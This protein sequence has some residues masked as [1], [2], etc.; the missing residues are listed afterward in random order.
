M[1]SRDHRGA[2]R[3][4]V[5]WRLQLRAQVWL[6]A[7]LC[8]FACGLR[9]WA[10]PVLPTLISDHM[11]LQ[12]G[13]EIHLWGRADSGEPISVNLAGHSAT[14]IADAGHRW[15]V[16][17]PALSAGGPF[18]LT[19]SGNKKIEVKDVMIGEV[20][21]ASGQSNMTFPLDSAEGAATEVPKANYPQIRLFTVP[22]RIALSPQENTRPT[23]WKVCTP[24]NA[25]SFSAVGYFFAREIHR[26]LNVPVG[27]VE[28]AW[29]G[30]AIED[31][32]SPHALQADAELKPLEG[33]SHAT[34]DEKTFAE[35]SLP[36]ELEFDDFELIPAVAGAP[37]KMLANFDDG[38]ARVSTSG[39]FS[40][41][42]E[43]AP[44]APFE[45]ASP[46]HS[47]GG[48]AARIVGRLDGTQDAI[49]SATYKL[50]G[51]A[52]D[53]T[54]YEGIRFWVRGNGSFRFRSKQPTVTDWDDYAAPVMKAS[55]DWKP[56]TVLFHDL[57]QEGWGVVLPFTQDALSGFTIENLT[58]VEYAPIPISGLYQGMITPLL[59][60]AFRGALWY[61]GES[62]ALKAHQYRKLLPAL[63]GGWRDALHDKD[64]EFLIV[65]LPNHGATPGQPSESAWAELR[66]AELLTVQRV[67]QTGLAVT[68]DV[69]DPNNVHPHRKLE[70]GQ[71]LALW[72]EGTIYHQPIEYSGPLYESM[73]IEGREAHVR[74]T[75]VGAGLEAHNGEEL[76]GF[77]VAG[78]DRQFH[79]AKA[80]IEG[81]A[82]AV[83]SPDVPAPVAV[84]YAWADSPVCNLFS[85]DGLPAS[86]FRT[87]DWPGITGK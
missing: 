67:P 7:G 11:V 31:W 26:R 52:M 42:W 28:S 12:Q 34:S 41:T 71:R 40:Y 29:P 17:L 27:V 43:D 5:N 56:V 46:G 16:R 44:D 69:G 9:C 21:I 19:V 6:A 55:S 77:A 15:S 47:G 22:R 84:R 74:F 2:G 64:L 53:L 33:V 4:I 79:W 72:A 85:K 54:S 37:G 73:K 81:N 50:D 78:A 87:D 83:S 51:S 57:R 82:V 61:Q 25:K 3:H 38:T 65:Q 59:P 58:T 24:D 18:T 48:F 10:D 20:W 35:S 49:L 36:L 63:I 80:R 62:N 39:T 75:H 66:E 8:V 13:R 30:T 86:P 32:I 1:V 14:A 68:I 76:R 45:L 60:S 23:A 70:V